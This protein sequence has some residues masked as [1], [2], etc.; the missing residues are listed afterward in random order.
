MDGSWSITTICAAC[1]GWVDVT[2]NGRGDYRRQRAVNISNCMRFS[3]RNK[4]FGCGN[5]FHKAFMC[6]MSVYKENIE[7]IYLY[8]VF[9]NSDI[10]S[11]DHPGCSCLFVLIS[12]SAPLHVST[13]G[14]SSKHTLHGKSRKSHY[15]GKIGWC[16]VNTRDIVVGV[17]TKMVT[18]LQLCYVPW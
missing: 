1:V 14:Q 16:L 9:V 10:F 6:C 3:F 5:V 13:E 12:I 2:D 18:R 15:D 4:L 17:H 11:L 8:T 7:I